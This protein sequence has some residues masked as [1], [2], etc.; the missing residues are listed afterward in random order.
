M[1]T[2]NFENFPKVTVQDDQIPSQMENGSHQPPCWKA[3]GQGPHFV[4][5]KFGKIMWVH[6]D[7]V[8]DKQWDSSQSKLK[9]KSYNVISLSQED[10][11]QYQLLSIVR[12]KKSLP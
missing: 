1:V 3:E 12:G 2:F 9:G 4:T 10:N 8:N 6:S 11:M 7:I 5:T